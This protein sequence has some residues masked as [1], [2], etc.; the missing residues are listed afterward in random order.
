MM[1]RIRRRDRTS[2]PLPVPTVSWAPPIVPV[3]TS[4]DWARVARSVEA[5][6]QRLDSFTESTNAT[7]CE[8]A[9]GLT[10]LRGLDRQRGADL[11]RLVEELRGRDDAVIEHESRIAELASRI[12]G[13]RI[14]V[15][16]RVSERLDVLNAAIAAQRAQVGEWIG[17][18]ETELAGVH[19][20]VGEVSDT[21]ETGNTARDEHLSRLSSLIDTERVVGSALDRRVSVV[22]QSVVE[23]REFA[24]ALHLDR[25][26]E[27]E[28]MLGEFSP[29]DYVRVDELQRLRAERNERSADF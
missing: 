15:D 7:L 4:G 19:A 12:D 11:E 20:R 8:M 5:M 24:D 23:R 22:E 6:N 21:L 14:A 9:A 3:M 29:D 26:E 16:G 18:V 17:V 28:R 27:M 10:A 1:R 25:L 13:V 2:K